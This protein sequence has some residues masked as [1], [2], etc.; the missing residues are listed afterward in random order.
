LAH[1]ILRKFRPRNGREEA[2]EAAYGPAGRD[3]L[4]SELL[5]DRSDPARYLTVDRSHE[6]LSP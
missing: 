3:T 5:K 4:G 2:F 1:V 6:T